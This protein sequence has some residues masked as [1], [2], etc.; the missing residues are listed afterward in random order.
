MSVHEF[1]PGP[2]HA[3][4]SYHL[5]G[6]TLAWRIGTRSGRIALGDIVSLRLNLTPAAS[7]FHS[8]CVITDRSGQRHAITEAYKPG[9]FGDAQ[10]RTESFM[11][12][13]RALLTALPGANP[14]AALTIGPSRTDWITAVIVLIVIAAMSIGGIALMAIQGRIAWAGLAF[15]GVLLAMAPGFWAMARSG[16]PKP[17][18]AQAWLASHP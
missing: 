4:R 5:D 9:F 14:A 15:I 16:G 18:D 1:R 11:A 3:G 2:L 17:L 7:Q 6:D 10:K 8:S 12:F 13:T